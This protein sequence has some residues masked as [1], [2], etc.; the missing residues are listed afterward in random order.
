V[1]KVRLAKVQADAL[2]SLLASFC[3]NKE[4][5]IF[6]HAQFLMGE[7]YPESYK[8]LETVTLQEL[9]DAVYHGYEVEFTPEEDIQ[10]EY[11]AHKNIASTGSQFYEGFHRGIRF[12]LEKL[13][14]LDIIGEV[15]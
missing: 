15:E 10:I 3:E 6:R 11:E 1:E 13:G 2:R 8:A 4:Q 14:R 9:C 7:K 12:T 5:T